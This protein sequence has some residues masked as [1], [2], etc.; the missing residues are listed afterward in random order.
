MCK[1][2]HNNMTFTAWNTLRYKKAYF[3]DFEHFPAIEIFE[4]IKFAT[5]H[6]GIP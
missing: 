4:K 2:G 5:N 3:K 1:T 6:I